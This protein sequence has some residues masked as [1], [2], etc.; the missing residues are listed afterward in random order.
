MAIA[1]TCPNCL[2]LFR[3]PDEL[4]GRKV[5]C[6]K[7]Q[8][9]FIVP[10]SDAT[11]TSP[12]LQASPAQTPA[13]EH[14]ATAPV[15]SFP[16]PPPPSV[17]P[18]PA[19]SEQDERIEE[20][21]EDLP[22]PAPKRSGQSRRRPHREKASAASSMMPMVL[23]LL[24]VGLLGCIG[25]T[26]VGA[27]WFVGSR[28]AAVNKVA[29]K[30]Q[31][32]APKPGRLPFDEKKNPQPKGFGI[33]VTLAPDGTFRSENFLAP[34]DPLNFDQVP[35]KLYLVRLE[36]GKTYQIDMTSNQMDSFL[37]LFDENDVFILEHD[38]IDP[39]RILDARIVFQ[40]QRTAV[41]R[42]HASR[43]QDEP[44]FGNFTLT[45][46]RIGN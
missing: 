41:Y 30:K 2:A 16:L 5:K 1:T 37:Y 34:N 4:A 39:G 44:R 46:R 21:A 20:D 11:M 10:S 23:V 29:A 13:E 22:L 12:G 28:H 15:P 6:Q 7:C 45:I 19:A 24:G 9:L 31:P 42:I 17:Q 38:D 35:F 33:N 18:P 36:A 27:L 40:A 26:G 43:F 14:P 25:C 3:L 8:G 32:E